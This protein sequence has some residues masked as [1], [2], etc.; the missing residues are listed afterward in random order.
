MYGGTYDNIALVYQ[1]VFLPDIVTYWCKW[2]LGNTVSRGSW[3]KSPTSNLVIWHN[4]LTKHRINS[5]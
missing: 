3:D 2:T 1:G 5:F 4:V